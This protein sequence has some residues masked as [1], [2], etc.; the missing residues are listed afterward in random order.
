MGISFMPTYKTEEEL[1][2]FSWPGSEWTVKHAYEGSDFY[3]QRL[4]EA[5]SSPET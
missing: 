4:D 1:R 2:S 5:A 3:R